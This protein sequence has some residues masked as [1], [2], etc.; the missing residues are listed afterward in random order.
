MRRSDEANTL[1]N[2]TVTDAASGDGTFYRFDNTREDRVDTGEDD[3][4]ERTDP[5]AVQ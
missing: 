3:D 2:L 1:A 4:R 5:E